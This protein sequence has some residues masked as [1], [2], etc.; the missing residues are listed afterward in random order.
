MYGRDLIIRRVFVSAP[1]DEWLD[2]RRQGIK[3]RIID[4]IRGVGYEP[5]YFDVPG[6]GGLVAGKV[7]NFDSVDAV[8]RRCVGAAILGLARWTLFQD[9]REI[10]IPSEYC[11]YEGSLALALGLPILAVAESDTP[12][13]GIFVPYGRFPVLRIPPQADAAWVDSTGFTGF[14]G[15]WTGLLGARRDIFLGYASSSKQTAHLIKDYLQACQVSVLDWHHDFAPAGSILTQIEEGAARCSAGIFLFTKDDRVNGDSEPAAPRDNV[16][17]E[18]GSF[19]HAKGKERVLIVRESGSRMPADLGG[20]I[21]AS[22]ED[23]GDIDP[24]KPVIA[25]F[26]QQR[27]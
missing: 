18:A 24:V 2:E 6:P 27:L 16:V 21:Y 15:T 11:H 9:Q 22:L 8:M 3:R 23:R 17:F 25:N 10:L 12:A 14:L 20:D 7:W 4:S 26:I 5:Q 19:A 13:R 1:R